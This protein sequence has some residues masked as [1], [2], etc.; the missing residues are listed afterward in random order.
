MITVGGETAKQCKM[1]D[2]T[3]KEIREIEKKIIVGRVVEEAI[4]VAMSTHFYTF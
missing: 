1:W 4:I 2:D 3:K